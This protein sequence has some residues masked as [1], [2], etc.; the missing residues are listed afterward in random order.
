MEIFN[1]QND[2]DNLSRPVLA[3]VDT[4]LPERANNVTCGECGKRFATAIKTERVTRFI[5]SVLSEQIHTNG[6]LWYFLCP[7]CGHRYN[8]CHISSRGVEL[9]RQL[10]GIKSQLRLAPHREDLAAQ[11]DALLSELDTQSVSLG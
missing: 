3:A 5:E 2:T 8:V 10:N 9:R 7:H 4:P 11:R 1:I 6:E